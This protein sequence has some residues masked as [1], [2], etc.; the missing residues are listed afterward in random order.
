M[1]K[2][3]EHSSRTLQKKREQLISGLIKDKEPDYMSKNTQILDDYFI[4]SFETSLVGPGMDISKKPYAIVALGGYGRQEQCL[5]SDVDILFLFQKRIPD[6]AEEL[7]REILYP[8]WDIGL[9][10]GHAT[11]TVKECISL[12]N[13]DFEVLVS[14]MDGRFICGMSILFSDLR[15]HLR[16]KTI[17]K[18]SKKIISWLIETNRERHERFGDST[19][20]LE[21][22]LKEGQGGLRDYHTML[23]I[24]GIKF[25]L[26]KPR[27]L[28]YLGY[29]SNEEFETLINS[30]SFIW[31]V[32]NRIHY[33]TKKKSDQLYFEYQI[34]LARAL[35]FKR[36]RGQQPVEIFLG[37]LHGHMEYIKQLHLMF[38]YEQ[39]YSAQ[40]KFIRKHKKHTCIDALEIKRDRL[41][42]ISSEEILH[43]SHL[44]IK[45]FEESARIKLPISLEANRIIKDFLYLVDEKF[46]SSPFVIK[47]FEK[48]LIA[49]APT[50]NVLGEMLRTGFLQK[51]IPEITG[52]IN[53]IQY[54]EYHIF[55]VDKHSLHTVQIIKKFGT[56][57]DQASDRLCGDIYKT[58]KHR[59]LLLWAA[60]LHDI[61]KGT[62]GGGHSEKGA[63]ISYN[64]L[65]DK[66]YSQKDASTVSFLVKEHLF[67]VKTATRRDIND[68]AVAIF[69]AKKIK[70]PDRLKM[71]YLL[72]VADS[73]ST[74]PKAWNDWTA[75]L[76]GSLFLKILNILEN[77]ELATKEAVETVEKKKNKI[78]EASIKGWDKKDIEELY[79]VMSPRYR[80]YIPAEDMIGHIKLYHRMG[81]ADFEWI[82]DKT[83]DSGTRIVTVC[84]RDKHGLFSKI[85]G[86]FT[87]NG[88]DILDAQVY[89]WLNNM[90][91]DIF[92]VKAPVDQI[93]EDEK[94]EKTKKDLSVVLS[95]DMDIKKSL[96]EKIS[97]HREM[98]LYT[99]MR[100]HKIVVDNKSSSFFTII[101]VFA[102]DFSGLLF[103]IT[104][105]LFRCGLDIL[106]AKIATKT[107]QVVD[108]FYVRDFD[109]QKVDSP[110]WEKK[111]KNAIEEVLPG[112]V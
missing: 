32:R 70:D 82:V 89:T 87:L 61:G 107:D 97:G 66:G 101:E 109:G 73:M 51:F 35:K 25:D 10:I 15:Y 105:A 41:N 60:L 2:I 65:I 78:L 50:F 64:I 40:K 102:Y 45:I 98:R 108:V 43:Y 49:Y 93:F 11:R 67:L 100:P 103:G 56:K 63:V 48:I 76:L 19:Y 90:A 8:L 18:R 7:I 71:L 12:A 38:L 96:H 85:A 26:K 69:C 42:F 84:A 4:T 28:E 72:S 74:G 68:E 53:I 77:G 34:K 92:K 57:E 79:N 112:S 95:G 31:N 46:I 54:D 17:K 62:S 99:T 47:A 33:I 37:E 23:W 30:L 24:A 88:L 81:K 9:E 29:L 6:K 80:L 59:K 13:Q 44:L 110:E 22:N 3:L 5:H 55:P 1:K 91:L 27:D 39:G 58:M 83:S 14:L 36:K 75:F 111:I 86:I 16:T 94:W 104:D 106:I 21:P 20:L 52:I